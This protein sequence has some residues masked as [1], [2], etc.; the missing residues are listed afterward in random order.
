M[1]IARA[2]G[3]RTWHTPAKSSVIGSNRTAQTLMMYG[4]VRIH[5]IMSVVCQRSKL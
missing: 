1:G 4:I 5:H 3:N 2:K